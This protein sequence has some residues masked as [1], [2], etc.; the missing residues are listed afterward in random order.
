MT[1]VSVLISFILTIMY[2]LYL[3]TGLYL[4]KYIIL[5][6]LQVFSSYLYYPFYVQWWQT[7]QN[8]TATFLASMQLLSVLI[9]F[10][11]VMISSHIV[12][13]EKPEKREYVYY[14]I[15]V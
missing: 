14:R 4:G 13:M 3:L 2:A 10:V 9:S 11:G 12:A 15:K 5:V 1:Q 6:P 8:G 7:V